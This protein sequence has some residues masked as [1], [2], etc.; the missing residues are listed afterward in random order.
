[1]LDVCIWMKELGDGYISESCLSIEYKMFFI[2]LCFLVGG[3]FLGG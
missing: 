2:S 3:V 1:M